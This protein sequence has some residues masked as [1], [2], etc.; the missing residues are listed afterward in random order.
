MTTTDIPTIIT[1][2]CDNADFEEVD[3]LTKAQA[4][5][6][7]ATRY[8]ILSPQSSSGEGVSMSLSVAQIEN[9]LTR[10]RMFV[11][12]KRSAGGMGGS[13]RVR[14]LVFREGFRR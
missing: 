7:A 9:L 14:V 13:P 8:L 3:S 2:L 12:M 10:A 5:V 6:T 4:F 1:A 11:E